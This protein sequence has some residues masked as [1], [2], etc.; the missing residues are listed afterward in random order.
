MNQNQKS[1]VV[2]PT[3]RRPEMLALTLQ[4]LSQTRQASSLDVRIYVDHTTEQRLDEVEYVRD[5]FFPT[6]DIFHAATHVLCPGGTWNI[7]QSLKSGYETGVE[8]IFFVEEDVFVRPE[9]FDRHLEMQASGD[10]FVTCGR[11]LPNR[12]EFYY[13]NPGTCYRRE[14]LALVIPHINDRYFAD[15]AGYVEEHFPN[16]QDAGTND[17]GLIRRVMQSVGGKALC[18]V[19]PT[20]YH[21]GFHYYNRMPQFTVEGTLPEK[22]EQLKVLLQ[23][24]NPKDRYSSDFEP[25]NG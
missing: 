1:V 12:D 24:V 21:Q 20:A 7:L 2:I 5:T 11:K 8:F 9:F 18:A 3:L 19:P 6:A 22:I 17:D 25:F 4:H 16:M 13:S 15:Q 23:K 10:Y 14:K